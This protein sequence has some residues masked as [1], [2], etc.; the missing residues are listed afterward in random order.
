MKKFF[1]FIFSL[2]ILIVGAFFSFI[3]LCIGAVLALLFSI[4][5]RY[6]LRKM[7]A[8]NNNWQ[9]D[10]EKCLNETEN[11][12]SSTIIEGEFRREE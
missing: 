5:W 12:P 1:I 9:E 8:Q 2:G 3:F 7:Q 11:P 10:A 4:W 6:K